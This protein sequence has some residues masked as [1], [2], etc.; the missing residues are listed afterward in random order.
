MAATR[1]PLRSAP[2]Q[3]NPST[4]ASVGIRPPGRRIRVPE[5]AV[6][7]LVTVVFGLGAVFWHLHAVA[8][9]PALATAT[10]IERGAVID[11]KDLRVVYVASD[12]PIDR[13]DPSRLDRVAGRVALVNLPAGSLL[14]SSVVAPVAIVNAGDAVVGLSLEPGAYPARGLAPGDRVTV[15]RVA[16]V[17]D[18]NTSPM[19]I[20]RDARVFAVEELPSDRRLVSILANEVDAEAVAASAGDRGVRLVMVAP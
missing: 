14:T 7:V 9:V 8:K 15:V 10:P 4:A 16:D 5:V 6:G 12:G 11:A 18:R 2:R 3:S 20:A 19:V 13:M 17:A 1:T